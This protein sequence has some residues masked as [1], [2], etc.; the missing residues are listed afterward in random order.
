[1]NFPDKINQ[2]LNRQ[3][4][5]KDEATLLAHDVPDGRDLDRADSNR[6]LF[7]AINGDFFTVTVEKEDGGR[8]TVTPITRVEAVTLYDRYLSK[9]EVSFLDAFPGIG[10]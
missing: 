6:F 2:I 5:G 10:F 9:Q 4:Y 3:L 7:R 1:M 8:E